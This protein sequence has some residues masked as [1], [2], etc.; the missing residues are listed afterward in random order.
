ITTIHITQ[1]RGVCS[2]KYYFIIVKLAVGSI[3]V[4]TIHINGTATGCCYV[5]VIYINI[6]TIRTGTIVI[7]QRVYSTGGSSYNCNLVIIYRVIIAALDIYTIHNSTSADI[8]CIVT[9]T[10]TISS[11]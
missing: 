5:I 9:Y 8:N 6:H 11:S 7:T 3:T 4:M 2:P 10:T 1:S